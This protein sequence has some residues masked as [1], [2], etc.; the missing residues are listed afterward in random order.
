MQRFDDL[1]NSLESFLEDNINVMMNCIEDLHEEAGKYH[2][3]KDTAAK[4]QAISE[5]YTAFKESHQ[6][7]P[8]MREI[9]EKFPEDVRNC[10]WAV[11]WR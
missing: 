3:F 6:R 4:S 10:A 8:T 5:F 2:R 9:Q 1:D 7:P 11:S